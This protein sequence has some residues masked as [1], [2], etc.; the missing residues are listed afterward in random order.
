MKK[1]W[2]IYKMESYLAVKNKIM[3]FAG[4]CMKIEI[5]LLSEVSQIEKDR[6]HM[7]SLKCKT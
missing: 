6:N 3:S 5:I 7:F 1:M 2:Y 4:K